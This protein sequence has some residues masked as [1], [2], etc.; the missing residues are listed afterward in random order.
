MLSQVLP[1]DQSPLFILGSRQIELITS[2]TTANFHLWFEV[3]KV[4]PLFTLPREQAPG[5]KFSLF[6]DSGAGSVGELQGKPNSKRDAWVCNKARGKE[7][8]VHSMR[9]SSPRG[10]REST[11]ER[12]LEMSLLGKGDQA[13]NR[14]MESQVLYPALIRPT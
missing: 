8:W 14:T 13:G 11:L 4:Y 7:R 1:V 9:V 2:V 10:T 12:N 6:Q 3:L 5:K